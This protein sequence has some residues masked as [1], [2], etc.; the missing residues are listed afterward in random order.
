MVFVICNVI[1]FSPRLRKCVD[2]TI[3]L[4]FRVLRQKGAHRSPQGVTKRY[5]VILAC[6][7]DII[8]RVHVMYE[9]NPHTCTPTLKRKPEHPPQ[10]FLRNQNIPMAI[11][12]HNG[13]FLDQICA[14]TLDAEGGLCTES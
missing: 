7:F 10:A 14:K 4:C 12:S 13:N 6:H 3:L 9:K 2:I 11:V 5:V 1:V 8:Q